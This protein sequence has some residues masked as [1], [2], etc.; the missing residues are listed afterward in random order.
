MNQER[1]DTCLR[2]LDGDLTEDELRDFTRL[3]AES[4]DAADL[5]AELALDE[6][7]YRQSPAES[8]GDVM[9]LAHAL[10]MPQVDLSAEAMADLPTIEYTASDRLTKQ[11]Y[12]SALSYVVSH[13]FTPKRVA[14]LATAAVVL[15]AATVFFFVI[16]G[17]SDEPAGTP[18]GG[19]AADPPAER[20]TP[21][22]LATT[23]DVQAPLWADDQRPGPDGFVAGQYRL[24]G[25]AVRLELADG[26]RVK[27]TAPVDFEIT[28]RNDIN[29]TYGQLVA[30]VPP[31]AIGF[32]V[33]T[34]AGD[35]V[36]LGTTFGVEVL[37]DQTTDVQVVEGLVKVVAK[38]EAGELG[39]FVELNTMQAA[40]LDKAG[41]RVDM[42]EADRKRFTM[43]FVRSIDLVDVV[44]G[45]D[46]TGSARMRGIN[47][48]NGIETA[49]PLVTSETLRLDGDGSY[50]AVLSNPLIDGVFIPTRDS[51]N[52]IDSTGRRFKG[53]RQ[54]DTFTYGLIW[55][56]GLMPSVETNDAL[57]QSVR[58]SYPDAPESAPVLYMLPNKGL[59]LD[60]D[61]LRKAHQHS[62]VMRLIAS[63]ELVRSPLTDMAAADVYCIVDGV[64]QAERL[65]I[66]H[67]EGRLPIDVRIDSD[68]RFLT[69]VV[70]DSGDGVT[71]DWL[72][73][74]EPR[75]EWHTS[76]SD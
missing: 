8:G 9:P 73:F 76:G 42:I 17:P 33:R 75:L 29:I 20:V 74:H 35:V 22:V 54:D 39:G 47:P 65:D 7:H 21:I 24:S 66:T 55:A 56:G 63:V 2:Y 11:H 46:G 60:L 52:Q 10:A 44:A 41:E 49:T 71:A 14:V 53:L 59:T 61:E 13:I 25:G 23:I 70:A 30:D 15:L 26:T 16:S 45:G 3:L 37:D 57:L 18:S 69:L 5:L 1:I 48:Q 62:G 6:Q 19:L 43:N 4:P 40:R 38:N 64:A 27:L 58:Q 68:A 51:E 36:D 67:M 34:P 50:N 32:R 12:A 31:Q 72:V 28:G